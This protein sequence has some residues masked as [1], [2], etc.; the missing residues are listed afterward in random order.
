MNKPVAFVPPDAVEEMFF[1]NGFH[2]RLT[3]DGA[4]N[5]YLASGTSYRLL[6]YASL[7]LAQ[8]AFDDLKKQLK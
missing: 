2:I 1:S 4:I 7:V 3:S 8:A 5:F 6:S